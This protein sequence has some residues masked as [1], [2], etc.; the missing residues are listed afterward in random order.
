MS[1]IQLTTSI[2][3]PIERVF[4]LARSIDLHMNS[5]SSTDERAIA[6][7][8]SGLIG[9]GQEVTWRARH[10][11]IW[12]CLTVRIGAFEPPIHFAD[13]MARGAFRRM[14][15][16]HYFEKSSSGTIMRDIFSYEAPLGILGRIAELLFLDRYL[17]SFL[18]ER[19]RVIKTAAES[20]AWTHYLG[21]GR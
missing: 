4:D 9:P 7:V 13:V 19:N 15:H 10:F 5:T 12:Q 8:T 17:R 18:V 3:A 16:H 2:D 1:V 11:G 6:G 14:E 21:R 20:D